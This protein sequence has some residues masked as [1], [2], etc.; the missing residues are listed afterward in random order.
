MRDIQLNLELPQIITQIDDDLHLCDE[1]SFFDGVR[2][3][4]FMFD[5]MFQL[6]FELVF[7]LKKTYPIYKDDVVYIL[8]VNKWAE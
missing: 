8:I 6:Y 5:H 2:S 1:K 7:I 3:E 4:R